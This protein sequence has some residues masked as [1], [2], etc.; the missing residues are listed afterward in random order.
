[1]LSQAGENPPKFDN[2][3]A[4]RAMM[5]AEAMTPEYSGA[6]AVDLRDKKRPAFNPQQ[7]QRLQ[8][9]IDD[10]FKKRF[11]DEAKEVKGERDILG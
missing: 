8:S 2:D 3:N 4:V 9:S 10:E 11:T 1:L 5:I 6:R 7:E